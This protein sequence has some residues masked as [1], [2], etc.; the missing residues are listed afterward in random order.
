MEALVHLHCNPNP[1]MGRRL[2]SKGKVPRMTQVGNVVHGGPASVPLVVVLARENLH[3]GGTVPGHGASRG[4]RNERGFA[5]CEGVP[6]TDPTIP[7]MGASPGLRGK[8]VRFR[9]R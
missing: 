8:I 7:A 6:Y 2:V 1:K 5:G 9:G 3:R 4:G